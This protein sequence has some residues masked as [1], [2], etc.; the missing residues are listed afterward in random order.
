LIDY[1]G[2]YRMIF[3][4][5]YNACALAVQ[6]MFLVRTKIIQYWVSSR[7]TNEA[8]FSFIFDLLW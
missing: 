6:V 5:Y 3:I 8:F 1:I 2:L 4:L 7:K